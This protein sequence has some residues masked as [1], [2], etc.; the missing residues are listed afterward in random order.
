MGKVRRMVGQVEVGRY[1]FHILSP[2]LLSCAVFC[3][4][5]SH[6]PQITL[7]LLLACCPQSSSL[8]SLYLVSAAV[9]SGAG[10]GSAGCR[11]AGRRWGPVGRVGLGGDGLLEDLVSEVTQSLDPSQGPHHSSAHGFQAV[12][13]VS[14]SLLPCV[15]LP[16]LCYKRGAGRCVPDEPA[17]CLGWETGC[18][19]ATRR[20]GE[21]SG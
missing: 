4:W 14:C 15:A 20:S 18:S 12:A 21:G 17:K 3:A 16:C 6:G 7:H 10:G 5:G 8:S 13:F 2:K 11:V 9:S 1:R 19:G